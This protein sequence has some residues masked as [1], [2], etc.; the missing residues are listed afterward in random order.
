MRAVISTRTRTTSVFFQALV[1]LVA[2]I[3]L[4]AKSA[5][6]AP[7]RADIITAETLFRQ[8]KTLIQQNTF[9]EA[10]P[11]LIE[12]HRLDPASGTLLILA[13]CHEAEGKTASAWI[14]LG[15]VNVIA[16]IENRPER[17]KLAQ[18]RL[19][20]IQKRL[21]YMTV[22]VCEAASAIVGQDDR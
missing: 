10:C 15:E 16:D 12:S 11:M 3:G 22:T 21:S 5:A 1:G 18:Q 6:A 14:A 8:A 19:A 9:S 7:S 4:I 13:Q 20:E 17:L 2:A